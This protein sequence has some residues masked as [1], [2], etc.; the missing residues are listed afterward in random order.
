MAATTAEYAPQHGTIAP[1]PFAE[2]GVASIVDASPDGE[3]L[4]YGNGSNVIVRS[5]SVS[6]Y[7][8]HNETQSPNIDFR[9]QQHLWC[10]ANTLRKSNILLHIR[11]AFSAAVGRFLNILYSREIFSKRKLHR[12]GWYVRFDL[13]GCNA[14]SG[15]SDVNGTVRVWAFNNPEHNLK[16]EV[17]ADACHWPFC[18]LKLMTGS[19]LQW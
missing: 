10:T 19:L 4:I 11:L 5:I 14:H 1:N 17:S 18:G 6:D 9:I 12:I 7:N 16:A 15:D 8:V 3:N 2:R 13:S